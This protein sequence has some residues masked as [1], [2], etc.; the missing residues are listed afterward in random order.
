MNE[1]TQYDPLTGLPD[2]GHLWSVLDDRLNRIRRFGGYSGILLIQFENLGTY[3]HLVGK[4]G[5]ET[6]IKLMSDRLK[7]CLWDLDDAIRFD[8]YQFV[9][10]AGSLTKM[11][12]IH[13]VMQKVTEY[14]S[15]P[16]EVNDY[17]LS[18]SIKIGITIIPNDGETADEL[19]ENAQ[20]ALHKAASG[21]YAYHDEML[22]ERIEK[23]Q[24]VK[25]AI[26]KTLADE[27]FLLMLQPKISA[28]TRE[29][30]GIEALV[31]M[32]DSDNNIV[33]PGEFIPVAETSNLILEIDDWVLENAQYASNE[34]QSKGID[35]P[36]SINISKVQF[37]NSASLL[38]KLHKL[39]A[40]E[41][42]N[43]QNIILEI[44]ES[45]ITDDVTLS[46]ALMTEIKS[47]GYQ[48]SIDG[49]GSG[50]SSLSVL[51]ELT[52]DEIKIDRQFL[53]NVPDDRKNTAILISIIMLG[54][55]MDFRVVVMGVENEKQFD[56]LNEY[57]CD[58]FQ[59][60]LISEA[61][62]LEEFTEWHKGFAT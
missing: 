26:L 61:M 50:F 19:M 47:M 11:E 41:G 40:N 56:L 4:V 60:F 1:R 48:I 15:V 23:Q 30:C 9:Y 27:S 13:I 3:E 42:V 5:I 38:S 54:K 37:K 29:V 32:R 33:A 55:A 25:A 17:S 57:G 31:R 22:A 20:G 44:S 58:E 53:D 39:A 18:P 12:D 8:Q 62:K 49:F 14:L 24:E 34:L 21:T 10:L 16:C 28:L 51:K 6:F 7:N 2:R 35:L 36:I 43:P 45:S 46:A 52:I 59:G